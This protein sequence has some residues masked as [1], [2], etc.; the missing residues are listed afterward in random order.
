MPCISVDHLTN[1]LR[2]ASHKARQSKWTIST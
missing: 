1:S 2:I